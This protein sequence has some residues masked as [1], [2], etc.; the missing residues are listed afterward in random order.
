MEPAMSVKALLPLALALASCAPSTAPAPV[1]TAD[2]SG[3][4]LAAACAGREWLV[5]PRP[6]R[7]HLWATYYV[8]T[9]G[10]A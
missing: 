10:S 4:A 9:C 3:K 6:T 8:G 2:Q 7:A 5:R 1:A